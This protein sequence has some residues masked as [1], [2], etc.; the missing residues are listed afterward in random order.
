MTA[1]MEDAEKLSVYCRRGTEKCAHMRPPRSC[2]IHAVDLLC[3]GLLV[4][5]KWRYASQAAGRVRMAFR[6]LQSFGASTSDPTSG[7]AMVA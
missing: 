7:L 5:T 1:V 6:W 3:R 2:S 4:R